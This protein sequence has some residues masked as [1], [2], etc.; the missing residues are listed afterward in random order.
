MKI[1]LFSNKVIYYI[2]LFVLFSCFCVN[3]ADSQI[4]YRYIVSLKD[5]GNINDLLKSPQSYLS[6]R[7]LSRR[8]KQ[9]ISIDSLDVPVRK[10][11][12]DTISQ[13]GS[14]IGCSKWHNSIMLGV[15]DKNI[16]SS[17]GKYDFVDS[18]YMVGMY[19]DEIINDVSCNDSFDYHSEDKYGVLSP[20]VR[21][22]NID[23]L[24]DLGFKGEDILI[25]VTDDGFCNVDKLDGNWMSRI[26]SC[27]DFINKEDDE[28]YKIGSHGTRVFSC[29]ASNKDNVI[30]GSAPESD[31]VLLR[32]EYLDAEQ[33]AE[34][35]YW[36]FA[37]E[38]ADSIG[39]DIINVSLGYSVY[40]DG[41]PI[42]SY[43][44][45]TGNSAISRSADIAVSRG[46]IV[47]CSAGNEGNKYWKKI[48]MPADG[49]NVV[50]V[51]ALK[52]N[53]HDVADYSSHGPSY[54][55]RTKPDVM[56]LGTVTSITNS[57]NLSVGTGTS[58]A[59]PL[60]AGGVAC[61]WQALSNK[62]SYEIVDILR[63]SSSNYTNPDSIM[64]YGVVDFIKAMEGNVG[65]GVDEFKKH[66]GIIINNH[67]VYISPSLLP[68]NVY[69]YSFS[70]I[71][72]SNVEVCDS[73]YEF[74]YLPS[75]M[76]IIKFCSNLVN[77]SVKVSI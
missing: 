69:I 60:V 77:Y 25:A 53:C 38:Y 7:S 40:D 16:I 67:Y 23:K 32:T 21:V 43:S 70:G 22:N 45:L 44:D 61:L 68:L 39:A 75:G 34:E 52:E 57:G 33:P 62:T 17:L 66:D 30:I 55:Q 73:Y 54:D 2:I 9:G 63:S 76:Y 11:Y 15:Y 58:F 56:S 19:N 10:E 27:K 74:P 72:L 26:I 49:L 46:M 71:L 36:T 50:S 29:I 12:I 35:F 37:A 41:F 65:S 59:S 51:G 8:V 24:H 64:G 14:I 47:V 18:V 1:K 48:T 20:A 6:E 28:V 3:N 5:K 4:Q 42:Y 31:Y 13:Y